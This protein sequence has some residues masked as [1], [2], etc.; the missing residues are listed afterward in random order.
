MSLEAE[1]ERLRDR[2]GAAPRDLS[3]LPTATWLPATAPWLVASDV[4][5]RGP[6][7]HA[8]DL[9]LG[10]P[11][12]GW[13]AVANQALFEPGPHAA[14]ALVV[15]TSEPWFLRRP[16]RVQPVVDAVRAAWRS[17][18]EPPRVPVLR[19]FAE[20]SLDNRPVGVPV[21]HAV[22]GGR[23][24][25]LS[26]MMVVRDSLPTR[27]LVGGD[28]LPILVRP[29]GERVPPTLIPSELWPQGL[30]EAWRRSHP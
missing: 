11:C 3:G 14:P 20:R 22:T 1:F 8:E 5:H 4:L 28:C 2:L 25:W 7:G 29:G 19:W 26:A 27:Q 13:I 21:P 10:E 30:V 16:E 12:L 6:K 18:L 23:V 15:F 24:V 9:Q 17:D